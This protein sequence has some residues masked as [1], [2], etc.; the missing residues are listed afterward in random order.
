MAGLHSAPKTVLPGLNIRRVQEEVRG[1]RGAEVEIKGAI[2]ADC[3]AGWDRDADID[4]S[5]ARIELL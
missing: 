5:C 4:V 1:R 2:G 3:H